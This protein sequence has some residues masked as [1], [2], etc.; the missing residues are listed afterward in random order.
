MILGEL[1]DVFDRPTALVR[2]MASRG[3]SY[4]RADM[5]RDVNFA[6]GMKHKGLSSRIQGE[7]SRQARAEGFERA[8]QALAHDLLPSVPRISDTFDDPGM[9]AG[10]RYRVYVK[11]YWINDETGRRY[12]TW[13]SFYTDTLSEDLDMESEFRWNFDPE[14]G[15]QGYRLDY[16]LRVGI[17][18]NPT[19]P[20]Q[21]I[22]QIAEL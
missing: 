21:V 17:A 7:F 16:F 8:Q 2:E 12:D 14:S 11:T 15:R 10:R 1:V 9:P 5:F 20:H 6:L 3:L 22:S 19:M 13:H 4:R 18:H